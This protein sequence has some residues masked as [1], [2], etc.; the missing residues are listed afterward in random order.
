MDPVLLQEETVVILDCTRRKPAM[1]GGDKLDNTLLT[2]DQGN[3]NQITARNRNR[4]LITVVRDMCTTTV[5]P[6]P[7]GIL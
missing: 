2:C 7:H 5:P 6:T 1:L 4:T 3:F